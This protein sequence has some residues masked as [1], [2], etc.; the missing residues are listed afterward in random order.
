MS[1][2]G[3]ITVEASIVMPV[4][5]L[6]IIAV[7]LM[8]VLE[9]Q[10]TELYTAVVAAA[11]AGAESWDSAHKD[12][13]T[14]KIEKSAL[15]KDGLYRR[16]SA[17]FKAARVN[18]IQSLAAIST[19]KSSLLPLKSNEVI[20]E[21]KDCIAFKDIEI[22]AVKNT[23]AS[24]ARSFMPYGLNKS[25][26]QSAAAAAAAIDPAEF[27][28]NCDYIIDL[29]KELEKRVPGLKQAGGSIREAIEGIKVKMDNLFK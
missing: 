11:A 19:E 14:G 24:K 17:S 1:N 26:L 13:S 12:I 18:D 16:F 21:I 20:V 10:K 22:T 5:V 29:E 27:I 28:R 2:K 25:N 6:S 8:S 4:V 7:I 23:E 15:G 3:S 9:F